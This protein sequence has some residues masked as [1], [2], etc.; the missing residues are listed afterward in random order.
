MNSHTLAILISK[1][2]PKKLIQKRGG[3]KQAE[4]EHKHSTPAR[5]QSLAQQNKPLS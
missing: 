5:Y 2:Y 1:V 3:A 4:A